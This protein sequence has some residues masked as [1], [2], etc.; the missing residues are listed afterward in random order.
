MWL[1]PVPVRGWVLRGSVVPV[2]VLQEGGSGSRHALKGQA[3]NC[4][5]H[6]MGQSVG[7]VD[8]ELA[9]IQREGR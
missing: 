2:Q 4:S 9:Q 7:S 6:L 8:T 1:G 3:G 5:E